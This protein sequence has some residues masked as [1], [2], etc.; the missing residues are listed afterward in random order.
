MSRSNIPRPE[1]RQQVFAVHE[2]EKLAE[3]L[4]GLPGTPELRSL[5]A[6]AVD[7]GIELQRGILLAELVD[8]PLRPPPSDLPPPFIPR[9]PKLPKLP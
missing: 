2:L 9:T 7:R 1:L 3:D 4:L 8:T 5:L 6:A